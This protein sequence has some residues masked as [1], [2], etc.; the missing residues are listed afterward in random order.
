MSSYRWYI[1]AQRRA[2]RFGFPFLRRKS[3]AVPRSL[4]VNGASIPIEEPHEHGSRSD[5]IQVFLSDCYQ[6]ERLRKLDSGIRSILDVGANCGWFSI[7]ARAHLPRAVHAY[8]PNPAVLPFLRHKTGELG[9]V[10]HPE[11]VGAQD[12]TVNLVCNGESNQARTIEGDD[13]RLVAFGAAI[14]RL[15]GTAD[16]VKLDC[17]GA[18]WPMLGEPAAWRAVRWLTMEYH[19]WARPNLTHRDAAQSV[20]RLGFEVLEQCPTGDYGLL[21]AHRRQSDDPVGRHW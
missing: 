12:G 18:E 11:A 3:F 4:T 14:E 19:L 16:L 21:L 17:E 13:I 20:T 10:V 9:V 15:G 2:R 7:V 8:E 1:N 5:F 6:L